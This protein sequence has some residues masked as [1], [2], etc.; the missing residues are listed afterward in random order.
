MRLMRT[1]FY[2][3]HVEAGA[4]LVDFSGWEMP[5]QFS[6]ILDEHR[7]V[8]ESVGLFDVSH[9]GELRVKG[10]RALDALQVLMTNDVSAMVDGQA[11]Y[12]VMCLPSGG[13]VDDLLV[14]RFAEDDFLICV[15]AANRQKDLDWVLEHNPFPKGAFVTDESARWAQVALQGRNALPIL[16]GLV[17]F[18]LEQ[19]GTYHFTLGAVAGV[20]GCIVA[21]TGYTGEDGYEIFLSPAGARTVWE[22][23]MAAGEPYGI[24]PV[25]LGARDTLRLESRYCLYGNDI[26]H[27]TSPLEAGL[28]WVT[29]LDK[30]APFIGKDALRAQKSQGLSRRLVGMVVERRIARPHQDIIANGRKVGHVTSGTRS[31]SLDL[32]IALGYVPRPLARPGSRLQVDIRGRLANAQVV[33]TPFYRR[34]Y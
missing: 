5:L 6:G 17:D 22:A 16:K 2:Q 25:G 23:L 3:L 9:M 21:R 28:G 7:A 34:P 14:Y 4:R 33:R 12:T 27:T 30:T 18:P 11:Q 20:T 13:I 29:K 32:N 31:P 26:D 8:R 24:K 1:P 10:P 15:N 19:V